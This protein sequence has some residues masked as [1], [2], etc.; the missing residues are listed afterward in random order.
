MKELFQKIG[1]LVWESVVVSH[2]STIVAWLLGGAVIAA[3][4]IAQ[5]VAGWHSPYAPTVAVVIG[6]VGSALRNKQKI[7]AARLQ[8]VP[9]QADPPKGFSLPGLMFVLALFAGAAIALSAPVMARADDPK[10]GGCLA[11][12]PGTCFAP[13]VSVNLVSIRISDGS[14][15]TTVDPGL[16]YGVSFFSGQWYRTGLSATFSLPTYDGGRRILPALTASF[17]EYVRVGIAC[18]LWVGGGFGGN[19][20]F[21]LGFGSDFGAAAK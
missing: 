2:K 16:G 20:Q 17:A 18:P 19:A 6:I 7:A 4:Q 12:H 8:A 3:D 9:D 13:S 1:R 10:F 21:L 11:A 15:T 5:A 14:V